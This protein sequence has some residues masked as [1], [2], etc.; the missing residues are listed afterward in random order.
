MGSSQPTQAESKK[1][2]E[3][4]DPIDELYQVRMA[5]D[6]TPMPLLSNYKDFAIPQFFQGPK[7][8]FLKEVEIGNPA[9]PM[10]KH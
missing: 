7:F 4:K 9:K 3:T 1:Q 5:Q 10:R 6:R 8:N 2:P